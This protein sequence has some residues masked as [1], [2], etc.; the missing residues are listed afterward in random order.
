MLSSHIVFN[1]CIDVAT[2]RR[3]HI[4]E[5]LKRIKS[6]FARLVLAAVVMVVVVVIRNF[7]GLVGGGSLLLFVS[8]LIFHNLK[9]GLG[10]LEAGMFLARKRNIHVCMYVSMS[11]GCID[12]RDKNIMNRYSNIIPSYSSHHTMRAASDAEHL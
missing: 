5:I 6:G 10:I 4:Y 2:T 8:I 11:D 7:L 1:S 3:K 9:V 12:A